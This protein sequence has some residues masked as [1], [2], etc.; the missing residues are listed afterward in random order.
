[1]N[2]FCMSC[3]GTT[4]VYYQCDVCG[5]DICHWCRYKQS[6]FWDGIRHQYC[7]EDFEAA[8]VLME[9]AGE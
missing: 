9:I 4:L 5:R 1:M 2:R 7:Q 8:M 3:S 6:I